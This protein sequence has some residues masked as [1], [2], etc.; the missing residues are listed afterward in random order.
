MAGLDWQKAHE[1]FKVPDDFH[2]A[3][4]LAI[5]YYGGDITALSEDLQ[6]QELAKRERKPQSEF[7][8]K[9]SWE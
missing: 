3:T 8:F 9:D 7:V 4:A 5:G 1:V 2:I 6:K